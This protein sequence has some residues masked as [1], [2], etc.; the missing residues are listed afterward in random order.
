MRGVL[1]RSGRRVAPTLRGVAPMREG[2]CELPSGGRDAALSASATAL[3][4]VLVLAI[5]F[6]ATAT[7]AQTPETRAYDAAVRAF[8]EGGFDP[9]LS[10]Y[11]SGVLGIVGFTWLAGVGAAGMLLTAVLW[12]WRAPADPRGRGVALNAA[13]VTYTSTA[14][15]LAAL[16]VVYLWPRLA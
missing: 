5:L 4:R 10:A 3:L 13:L 2:P 11:A 14:C 7:Q 16:A 12:A 8:Q 6:C 15:W 9:K 1:A